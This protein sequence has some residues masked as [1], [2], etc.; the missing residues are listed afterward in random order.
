MVVYK[1]TYGSDSFVCHDIEA[2]KIEIESIEL[3][4]TYTLSCEEMN[5]DE[6]TNLPEFEG[7]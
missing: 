5:D 4:E 7:F 6:Y 3:G 2:I 1:L